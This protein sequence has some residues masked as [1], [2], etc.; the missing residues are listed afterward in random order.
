[1]TSG[2]RG[3]AR[4]ISPLATS[5]PRVLRRPD[6]HLPFL[7]ADQPPSPH[8]RGAGE[9]ES[10]SFAAARSPPP[11]HLPGDRAADI[12]PFRLGD[13]LL[14]QNMRTRPRKVSITLLTPPAGLRQHHPLRP[15]SF[16]QFDHQRRAADHGTKSGRWY[17]PE[18]ACDP[19]QRQIDALP[20]QQLQRAQ[21]VAGAGYRHRFIERIAAEQFKLTKGSGPVT[22]NRRTNARDH[23]IEMWELTSFAGEP[24]RPTGLTFIS[25]GKRI[26][27]FHRW[28]RFC[29]AS[30]SDDMNKAFHPGII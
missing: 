20:R 6:G 15:A 11:L 14:N 19:G 10:P 23:G 27:D 30:R 28:P 18:S 9:R 5:S 29:A 8:R 24:M 2:P 26:E 4:R 25:T 17:H 21:L 7:I 1:M 12:P 22:G 16:H 13:I 3:R